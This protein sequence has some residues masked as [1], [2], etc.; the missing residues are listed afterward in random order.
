MPVPGYPLMTAIGLLAA[1]F[2]VCMYATKC[3]FWLYHSVMTLLCVGAGIAVGGCLLYGIT[4]FDLIILLFQNITK[5][6]F[7]QIVAFI[8][9][10]FGG[11]VFYG[12]LIGGTIGGLLYVRHA[13]MN[14][15]LFCDIVAPGAALFHAFGRI[16][17][18]L[19]GCC[20]GIECEVGFTMTES[21]VPGANGDSR[22][23]IQLVESGF[24]FILFFLLWWL[25]SHGKLQKRLLPLYF[26]I[27]PVGRFILEF[28]RGDAHRGIY[29]GVSTSQWI[30]MVLFA[31]ATVIMVKRT[32]SISKSNKKEVIE[33]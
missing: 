22:F 13:K 28:F 8:M 30:S 10:I 4:N 3:G 32:I 31:V 19:A 33:E 11:S 5:L 27:Y 25:F 9:R 7:I 15:G 17:C 24:E 26:M 2:F 23:P 14:I 12:G 6:T 1:G 20:Y 16:G 29:F 21:E 18:F